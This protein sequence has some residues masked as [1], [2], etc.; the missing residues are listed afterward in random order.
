M[1]LVRLLILSLVLSLAYSA[2]AQDVLQGD[3]QGIDDASGMELHLQTREGITSGTLI[4]IDG[5]AY[6]LEASATGMG[7]EGFL[8]FG[9]GAGI[10]RLVPKPAGVIMVW[11]PA[12]PDGSPDFQHAAQFVF[13]HAFEVLPDP[14]KVYYPEPTSPGEKVDAL[15]FL[16]NYEF[17]GP[18]GVGIGYNSLK[19]KDK[20]MIKL[21]PI[22]Q[23]DILWK[24]C[25]ISNNRG[26]GEALRGQG[27]T[28][29]EVAIALD[30]AQRT[31]KFSSYKS[32]MQQQKHD[33]L[34][35]VECS[36]GMNNAEI[37]EAATTQTRASAMSMITVG[38]VLDALSAN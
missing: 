29:D 37:C 8:E 2:S 25:Q 32:Q 7:A 23:S 3:Y 9:G 36:R 26:L 1:R 13:V 17:W 19:P 15:H 20:R 33:L 38:V 31:G 21:F 16:Y 34:R 18:E 10:Y 12:L 14:P 24:L 28:C 5:K 6:A 11:I 30:S 35:A 22:V 27:A 4:G